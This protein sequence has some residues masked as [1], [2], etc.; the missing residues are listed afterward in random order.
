MP[1]SSR[2]ALTAVSSKTDRAA[3]AA[4]RRERAV[5]GD[6]RPI[7][8]L[9]RRRR[10]VRRRLGLLPVGLDQI[11]EARPVGHVETEGLLEP[12]PPEVRRDHDHPAAGQ[13]P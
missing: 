4:A 12:R 6:G 8:V 5:P 9:G 10:P 7:A 1:V 11:G 13:G 3:A 2:W